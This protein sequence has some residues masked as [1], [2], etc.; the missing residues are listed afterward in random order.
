MEEVR[1]MSKKLLL[2]SLLISLA[3]CGNA[4]DR[5]KYFAEAVGETKATAYSK[6]FYKPYLD[7]YALMLIAKNNA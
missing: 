6:E 7:C 5:N 2:T 1:I 3:S 4:E